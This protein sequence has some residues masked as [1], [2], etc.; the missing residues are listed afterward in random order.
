MNPESPVLSDGESEGT[1]GLLPQVTQLR[2]GRVS[3]PDGLLFVFLMKN[4][5]FRCQQALALRK[6]EEE[7]GSQ[8]SVPL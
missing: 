2:K 1:T 6:G 5:F 4:A 7:R 8:T 3:L